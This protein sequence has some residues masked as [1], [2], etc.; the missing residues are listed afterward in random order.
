MRYLFFLIFIMLEAHAQTCPNVNYLTRENSPF[1]HIP[2]NDQDGV[3]I[4]YAY[5]AAQLVDYH[6]IRSRQT[7]GP[8][9]SPA[10]LALKSSRRILEQGT[11]REAISALRSAGS[12]NQNDVETALDAFSNGSGLT[13]SYLVSFI[14]TYARELQRQNRRGTVTTTSDMVDAAYSKA[15]DETANVCPDDVV[16]RRIE[17]SLTAL[18]ETSVQ[19][20]ARLLRSTCTTQNIHRY[21]I[22][23][24]LVA[25]F[26]NNET[27][28]VTIDSQISKGPFTM[29]YCSNTWTDM[30]YNM[31]RSDPGDICGM[32]SSMVVGRKK[33][34]SNCFALV[35]NSWGTGWGSWNENEIC[36]CKNKDSGEW[37]DNC[38][39]ET[40]NDGNHTV[41]ACY[42]GMNRLS[43]NVQD[44]TTFDP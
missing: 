21:N 15:V 1:N 34:G 43:H 5:T 14:E 31:N 38:R 42:I 20:F 41:E 25:Q 13:G 3:G 4:C 22:P 30:N 40:H 23:Q 26:D 8:V 24:P 18:N 32:H 17:P 39:A 29:A 6:L 37:V 12:C 27:A 33:I 28:K 19:M 2:V 10:W 44:I 36:L 7:S 11:E 9:M 16:W 35:R